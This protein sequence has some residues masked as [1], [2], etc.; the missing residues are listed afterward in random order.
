MST[1]I[2]AKLQNVNL[3][4]ATVS[5]MK[6]EEGWHKIFYAHISP[7]RNFMEKKLS[8]TLPENVRV[9]KVVRGT[10]SDIWEGEVLLIMQR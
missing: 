7:D 6:L 9:N 8:M 4:V 10:A 1:K 5:L 3:W 2:V